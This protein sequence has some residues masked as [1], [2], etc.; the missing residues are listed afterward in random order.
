LYLFA[1]I[2]YEETMDIYT[3]NVDALG[4]TGRFDE[5]RAFLKDSDYSDAFICRRYHLQCPEDFELDSQKRAPLPALE[6][7]ADLL[8]TLFLAGEKVKRDTA[9]R[10]AH[11]DQIA[12]LEGMGLLRQEPDSGQYYAPVALYPVE[13]LYIVSDRWSNPDDSKYVSEQDTVYPAFIPNTR[14]FLRNLPERPGS[15]FL[16]LCAGTGIAA[17]LAA[18]RGAGYAWSGD[19]AERSTRFAEF[20]RRLNGIENVKTVTSDLYQSM[21]NDCFDVIVAHPPYVPTIQPRWIFF[22]GGKDGEEITRRIIEGLPSHLN[23]GG[24]FF[25]LTMGGNRVSQPFERRVR[26]WL[27][28]C[29]QEFDIAFLV[30]QE[31][32][33]QEFALRANRETIRT[34]EESDLW[35][36][37]FK[38]LQVISL[39]YGF[40]CIQR[41]AEALK[42]FTVR[43]RPASQTSRSPWEWLLKWETASSGNELSRRLLDSP[44]HASSHTEFEVLHKIEQNAWQPSS[45]KLRIDYP[46]DMECDAQPWMAHM[47]SL[48]NGKST[49]R[50]IFLALKENAVFPESAREDEFARAAVSL[51]SGGFIE[52]EGFGPPPELISKKAP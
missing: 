45:Y 17:L 5:V 33:P 50:E 49:G 51:A 1:D 24:V 9:M 18:K 13:E 4:G 43:R 8:L 31:I 44:L 23:E 25:C 10:F 26:E 41:R 22:S 38:D 20:N 36:R 14:L 52:I 39:A 37:F 27:G 6:S 47:I 2:H 11:A 29:A 21:G 35:R 40:L 32:D 46:F 34:R 16:D 3:A 15:T 12:L 30:R 42:P 28:D 48:C 19:I 7:T